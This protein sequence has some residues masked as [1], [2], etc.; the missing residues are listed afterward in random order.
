[1]SEYFDYVEQNSTLS[2]VFAVDDDVYTLTGMGEEATRIRVVAATSNMFDALGVRPL[3]GHNL[4]AED[5]VVVDAE[6]IVLSHAMW[7]NL[8]ND[9][10][11]LGR[12]LVIGGGP[13]EIVGVM[14]Q[15]YGFPDAEVMA[16]ATRGTFTRESESVR[17]R[18]HGI[19]AY[20]RMKDGVSLCPGRLS[21][22][23]TP[24]AVS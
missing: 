20:A 5:E 7:T 17:R 12:I 24:C 4:T 6:A 1:M 14:P 9:P 16:W 22:S 21:W 18:G 19:Q 23:R 15:G 13:V 3:L 11:I 8:G 10:D 2:A